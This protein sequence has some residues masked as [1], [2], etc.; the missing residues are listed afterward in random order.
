[1][2]NNIINKNS[3]IK[4]INED[5]INKLFEDKEEINKEINKEEEK[6]KKIDIE[7]QNHSNKNTNSEKDDTNQGKLTVFE[8]D[9]NISISKFKNQL[10]YAY[11]CIKPINLHYKKSKVHSYLFDYVLFAYNFYNPIFTMYIIILS[12]QQSEY[13]KD[14]YKT[15]VLIY[16][17]VYPLITMFT[18]LNT[19]YYIY[20]KIFLYYRFLDGGTI[21]KW[22]KYKIY[23]LFYFWWYLISLVFICAG[24]YDSWSTL[25]IFLNQTSNLF[26]YVY[27]V[28]NVES[29]LITINNFFE[30]DIS[31]Q[32]KNI[33]KINWVNEKIINNNID[34]LI[35][36]RT[37]IDKKITK[38][39]KNINKSTYKNKLKLNKDSPPKQSPLPS[40]KATN[41][42]PNPNPTSNP[43]SN[44][45]PNTTQLPNIVSPKPVNP[46]VNKLLLKI[47]ETIINYPSPRLSPSP[48]RK[49]ES[50]D[51]DSDDDVDIN[52]K[53]EKVEI[54]DNEKLIEYYN[55]LNKTY[56]HFIKLNDNKEYNCISAL[57]IQPHIRLKIKRQKNKD[58]SCCEYS[59]NYICDFL[60]RDWTYGVISDLRK[61]EGWNFPCSFCSNSDINLSYFRCIDCL[62]IYCKKCKIQD[63]LYD[64]YESEDRIHKFI[65]IKKEENITINQSFDTFNI[66]I[67]QQLSNIS[68][69]S[70]KHVIFYMDI[71]YYISMLTILAVE[72]YG[73]YMIISKIN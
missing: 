33:N 35:T 68:V 28:V 18:I 38:M 32:L 47:N 58:T 12:Y 60:K 39:I 8:V 14:P 27:N 31:T 65:M 70:N 61:I 63:Q 36:I 62:K 66:P 69:L 42:N 52:C 37:I 19:S 30:E 3:K 23:K 56:S 21:F 64:C 45:N 41:T 51:S 13:R 5:E 67:C 22:N 55:I 34:G 6:V 44:S 53:K 10:N 20:S 71:I 59:Y 29:T 11:S 1:M 25:V 43:N 46:I 72:A 49:Q 57:L 4:P 73:F 24:L 50:K 9:E 54:K 16:S 26:L 7:V 48:E 15:F 17:L 40:P 2:F